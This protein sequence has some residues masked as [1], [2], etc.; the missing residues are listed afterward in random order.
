MSGPTVEN[1]PSLQD[2]GLP[3]LIDVPVSAD[4]QV[5]R[6]LEDLFGGPSPFSMIV[7]L[8]QVLTPV[9]TS[10][11]TTSW[12]GPIT[13]T[14]FQIDSAHLNQLASNMTLP[15]GG[16]PYVSPY[17]QR[18]TIQTTSTFDL[19]H[20]VLEPLALDLS[21]I[22]VVMSGV[23]MTM[24]FQDVPGSSS[25][26][27]DVAASAISIISRALD[28]FAS[29]LGLVA[30]KAQA[31]ANSFALPAD[32]SGALQQFTPPASETIPITE[33][34]VP[35]ISADGQTITVSIARGATVDVTATTG[36]S[37][38][39]GNLLA[40]ALY[41]ESS[42]YGNLKALLARYL[43]DLL[44]RLPVQFQDEVLFNVPFERLIP[45]RSV[46]Y[47]A[48]IGSF[49]MTGPTVD[50]PV[51]FEAHVGAYSAPGN[52]GVQAAVL[53]PSGATVS[54]PPR[55]DPPGGPGDPPNG[56]STASAGGSTIGAGGPK[57]PGE[58]D[59][60]SGQ[61]KAMQ[62]MLAEE[63]VYI[64][65]SHTE[66]GGARGMLLDLGRL[67]IGSRY[68]VVIWISGGG[69]LGAV[70]GAR[71]RLKKA[72]TEQK[73]GEVPR[74]WDE[75]PLPQLLPNLGLDDDDRDPPRS[76]SAGDTGEVSLRGASTS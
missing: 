21:G 75:H 30:Q 28:L 52:A 15:D 61:P 58:N 23:D 19:V 14:N 40:E 47:E 18:I 7:P 33:Y 48:Q 51:V 66:S 59:S 65:K 67:Y 56:S 63:E 76:N 34:Q 12:I 54:D 22:N 20:V 8:P 37:K 5:S 69:S 26:T 50:P 41:L 27:G 62:E 25:F 38:L 36:P 2:L 44:P 24:G 45:E 6:A 11:V 60:G 4:L 17:I 71:I 31:L 9:G 68:G 64:S 39:L 10:T 16:S 72:K 57:T 32:L 73:L 13:F 29:E 53:D 35:P 49:A 74:S 43:R 70:G 55:Q 46:A 42:G 1:A 3:S